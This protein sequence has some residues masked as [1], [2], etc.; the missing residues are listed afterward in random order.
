MS[1]KVVAEDVPDILS[2]I[3]HGETKGRIA[4]YYG[5]SEGTIM[6]VTRGWVPKSQ[7]EI[8]ALRER[9][10]VGRERGLQRWPRAPR[11]KGHT[12]AHNAVTRAIETGRLVPLPCICGATPTEAH[13]WHGYDKEHWLDVVWLCRPHHR[14]AHNELRAAARGNTLTTF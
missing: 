14:Q 1:G 13:H 9:Q 5:V 4:L 11:P 6:K 12:P 3:E 8:D 2:R 7:A 10:R